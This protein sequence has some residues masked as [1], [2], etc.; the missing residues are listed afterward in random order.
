MVTN[1]T[2]D[3]KE[4]HQYVKNNMTWKTENKREVS[5]SG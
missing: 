3:A 5:N 2:I 1:M 4:L